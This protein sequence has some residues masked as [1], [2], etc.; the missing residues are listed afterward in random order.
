[1]IENNYG[2]VIE[3]T[4]ELQAKRYDDEIETVVYRICQE[5]V[6]N[7][8]KYAGIDVITER[9]FEDS[10]HLNLTV[11]DN[12]AVYDLNS[13]TAIGNGLGIYGMRE[14]AELV[15]GQVSN[16]TNIEKGTPVT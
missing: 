16:Q 3:F 7:A 1:M 6:F 11:T 5:A 4:A 15:D 13:R 14:S 12:G 9:L 2:F 8:V 10:D